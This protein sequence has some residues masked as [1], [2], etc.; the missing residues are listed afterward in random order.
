MDWKKIAFWVLV[1]VFLASTPVVLL[2]ASGHRWDWSTLKLRSTGSLYLKAAPPEAQI[3]VSGKKVKTTSFLSGS[4]LIQHLLPGIYSVRIE[5]KKYLSWEK[6]LMIEEQKTTSFPAIYLFPKETLS[7]EIFSWSGEL[8]KSIPLFETEEEMAII[9]KSNSAKSFTFYHSGTTNTST[10][11]WDTAPKD[12][13]LSTDATQLIV[14]W[15][16]NKWQ[17][18][19]IAVTPAKTILKSSELNPAIKG[20]AFWWPTN[21][22]NYFFLQNGQNLYRINIASRGSE[23]IAQNVSAVAMLDERLAV[24]STSGRIEVIDEIGNTRGVDLNQKLFIPDS[25][26]GTFHIQNNLVSFMDAKKNLFLLDPDTREFKLIDQEVLGAKFSQDSSKILYWTEREIWV[27]WLKVEQK[28]ME[29]PKG[30]RELVARFSRNIIKVLWFADDNYVIVA[31]PDQLIALEIDGRDRRNTYSLFQG[32]IKN[33]TLAN[34]NS[35]LIIQPQRIIKLD[36]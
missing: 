14:S 36:I 29:F 10:T 12:I 3:F 7:Q 16:I 22:Q 5:K 25:R 26:G 6:R 32:E 9:E 2:Y 11:S 31:L 27:E 23:R 21:T 18:E 35:L 24:L 1:L 28:G 13:V 34:E 17:V 15:N 20:E 4:G 33:M 19:N 8:F 30:H